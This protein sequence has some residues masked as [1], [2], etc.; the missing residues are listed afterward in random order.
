MVDDCGNPMTTGQVWAEFEN[1]DPPLALVSLKNGRFAGTWIPRAA[2]PATMTLW[3]EQRL[4]SGDT[5]RSKPTIIPGSVRTDPAVPV[6]RSGGVV[7]SAAPKQLLP[8]APGSLVSILGSGLANSAL[9]GIAPLE[10]TLG[11]TTVLLG[12]RERTAAEYGAL[13]QTAGFKLARVVPMPVGP[14]IV[15]AVPV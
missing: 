2:A 3:A 15:E 8:L 1:G 7:S 5:L 11:G 13:F 4:P 6:I 14:S 10:T 9:K 12:A